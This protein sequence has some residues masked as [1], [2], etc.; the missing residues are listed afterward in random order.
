MAHRE[1][2]SGS[3]PR[4][5]ERP[6]NRAATDRVATVARGMPVYLAPELHD[7]LDR[8][9]LQLAERMEPSGV[10]DGNGVDSQVPNETPER[11]SNGREGGFG[12]HA[13]DVA[14]RTRTMAGQGYSYTQFAQTRFGYLQSIPT[15]QIQTQVKYMDCM[16][17]R[18]PAP[19]SLQDELQ[20]KERLRVQL[21]AVAQKALESHA[22]KNGYTVRSN[23]I[24]FKCCGSLRTGFMLPNAGLDLVAKIHASVPK[25]LV[26][27]CPRILEKAF[28]EAGFG[29]SLISNPQ[30]FMIKMCDEPSAP[31]LAFLQQQ[32]DKVELGEYF[33][34]PDFV[35]PPSGAGIRCAIDL[36]GRLALY[37][38]ELIRCYA[39]CD[40]RVR[41]VGVF[42]KLWA[43]SRQIDDLRNGTLCPHGYT[44][45][46][47]HYLMNIAQPPVLPNLQIVEQYSSGQVKIDNVNG[48]DVR[49]FNNEAELQTLSKSKGPWKN[50]QSVGELLRGFF[51]YY[52]MRRPNSSLGCLSWANETISIRTK[53]GLRH[54]RAKGWCTASTDANGCRQRFLIAIED[55]F[56]L[57]RNVASAVTP[58]GLNMV[59]S[60]FRRAETIIR[61]VQEIPGSGWEWR[62]NEGDV[63]KD[64]LAKDRPRLSNLQLIN[65]EWDHAD[66]VSELCTRGEK[67]K[68]PAPAPQPTQ[69]PED[70]DSGPEE[71]SNGQPSL[72]SEGP[73][74]FTR[75]P[76][77]PSSIRDRKVEEVEVSDD[78]NSGPEEASNEQSSLE[79]ET[80]RG[81][82][83]D[84]RQF[85]S[86]SAIR[87]RKPE[88][89]DHSDEEELP[90]DASS[91]FWTD[92]PIPS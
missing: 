74:E 52:S 60:E 90:A 1:Q 89:L 2:L 80:P 71:A 49:F 61:R 70:H 12:N 66:C 53:G 72:G 10:E 78:H 21:I 65:D 73:G 27:A 44:L 91:D 40:E 42:V 15:H 83:L 87:D 13:G 24:D 32:A 30:A 47:I 41:Q 64:L 11:A 19:S 85:C 36:S 77:S 18:I 63:G 45:M 68:K 55:P 4:E 23:A 35:L 86:P 69:D 34:M 54:K 75:E 5:N 56:E 38:A 20:A 79:R 62:T 48:Y 31:L 67:G 17:T 22:M 46:V 28:L 25:E 50:T 59:Q 81:I 16:A 6:I 33:M 37:S 76:H 84:P 8:A 7:I 82:T 14:A 92:M 3:Y 39:L 58:S 51:A 9:S 29:A 88:D 26:E 43:Q 57:D